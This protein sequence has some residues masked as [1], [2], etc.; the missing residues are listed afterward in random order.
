MFTSSDFAF[1]VL[2][3][4]LAL[5]SGRW[6]AR[7]ALVMARNRGRPVVAYGLSLR[8][9]S[10]AAWKGWREA[11]RCAH[12]GHRLVW[13]ERVPV[14]SWLWQHGSCAACAAPMG[15]LQWV[16]EV[17][18]LGLGLLCLWLYGPG[19]GAL[20]WLLFHGVLLA[21]VV[22]VVQVGRMAWTPAWMGLLLGL[23][24]SSLQGS[25]PALGAEPLGGA[26][27]LWADAAP[28]WWQ[29]WLTGGVSAALMGLV[30][31]VQ[32]RWAH[33]LAARQSGWEEVAL[34]SLVSVW[35]G[36]RA[37]PWIVLLSCVLCGLQVWRLRQRGQPVVALAP[38]LGLSVLVY[39]VVHHVY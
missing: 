19:W 21:C 20:A 31:A 18:A 3:L 13:Y 36:W 39:E 38:A 25:L 6:A 11:R 5:L 8:A 2:L 12:C 4:C 1:G 16:C 27:G 24:L 35:M 17:G 26:Q 30:L 7:V 29:V 37:L 10:A 15:R 34:L 9:R 23:A 28:P 33:Q 22:S 14:V 32:K